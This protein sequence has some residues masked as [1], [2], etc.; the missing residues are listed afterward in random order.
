MFAKGVGYK[1]NIKSV[2]FVNS[3]NEQSKKDI[4]KP[5]PSH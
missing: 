4:R 2:V 5:I 1:I 3:S